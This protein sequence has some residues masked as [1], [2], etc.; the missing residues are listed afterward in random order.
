MMILPAIDIQNGRCV[1]LYKGDFATS[2]EVAPDPL[3]AA[4]GFKAA[5]AVWVH[6]VDLD[7]A[8]AGRRQ[9]SDVFLKV[10]AE[11]GLLVELGGGI[12]DMETI[13]YYINRGIGRVVLGTAAIRNPRLVEEAAA[14][15]GGKIAVGVDAIEGRV[16]VEGWRK[17]GGAD[18]LDAAK[19][20]E[21]A[22]AAALI[23][24]DISRDG[25]LN[26]PNLRQLGALMEHVFCP[27]IA[28]GGIRGM[29]DL[30]ALKSLGVYGAI[31]GKAVYSGGL[32]LTQA[33][34]EFNQAER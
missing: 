31:C 26:G 14:R 29:E 18:Y 9:N 4:A 28:S 10:A 32:D 15:F 7:G 3:A 12:R 24:T 33:F 16:M 23:F 13:A 1:R 8:A 17:E 21:A 6:M 2:H 34:A 19:R 22:G 30:L 5:G 25:A 20:M 11:S 27:I